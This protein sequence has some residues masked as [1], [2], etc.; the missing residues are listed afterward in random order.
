MKRQ[1]AQ[2]LN[3]VSCAI[4]NSPIDY[5]LFN[6]K[7]EWG[8]IF[9]LAN[10]QTVLGL[11]IDALKGFD[12]ERYPSKEQ[13]YKLMNY[14]YSITKS[15]IIMEHTLAEVVSTIKEGG[16]TPVL[17][18]GQGVAANYPNPR[19]R[20]CGDIDLYIGKENYSKVVELLLQKSNKEH[21]SLESKKHFHLQ[22]NEVCVELHRC[23]D[24]IGNPIINKRFQQW[25]KYHLLGENKRGLNFNGVE[26]SL[27]PLQFDAVFIF[28]HLLHHFINGG[29]GLRQICDWA[30]FLHKYKDEIDREELRRDLERFGLMKKWQVFGALVVKYLKMDKEEVP[31]YNPKMEKRSS[32]VINMILVDGN[33]GFH[34][35]VFKNR[36]KNYLL[37]KIYAYFCAIIRY[38]KLS[39]I[40]PSAIF[41]IFSRLISGTIQVCMD[42]R[43]K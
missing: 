7:I 27:P 41:A 24:I 10:N 17:L 11:V 15:N 22:V 28:N 5:S 32:R 21:K 30:L 19:A 39:T 43:A 9:S 29:V 34:N 31:F 8:A 42:L 13:V 14:S 20:N 26:V 38:F 37:G 36:P 1:E 33:F 16:V 23:A 6:D 25:T 35:G 12:K 18:K 40:F 3:L 2:L 4:F